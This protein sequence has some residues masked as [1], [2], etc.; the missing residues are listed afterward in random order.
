MCVQCAVCMFTY[1][2]PHLEELYAV[3]IRTGR[4]LRLKHRE[5]Q[6]LVP[7]IGRW[8][9]PWALY[10]CEARVAILKHVCVYTCVYVC[11]WLSW[12]AR[13]LNG[14]TTLAWMGLEKGFWWA[15][16]LSIPVL[17]FNRN[18]KRIYVTIVF[19]TPK[20]SLHVY[21]CSSSLFKTYR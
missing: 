11:I 9:L 18:C 8:I 1:F 2:S 5:N 12:V 4:Q 3:E 13:T 15:R 7:C 20:Y 19:S 16:I 17:S 21:F 14:P 6:I 10:V